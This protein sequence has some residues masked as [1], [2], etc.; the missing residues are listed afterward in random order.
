MNKLRDNV[1]TIDLKKLSIKKSLHK[2][3]SLDFPDFYSE[4]E[5]ALL[6][7]ITG[8]VELQK[9]HIYKLVISKECF[10]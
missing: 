3:L 8:L 10:S 2:L 9:N 4:N 1:V 7:A 5:D 6:S